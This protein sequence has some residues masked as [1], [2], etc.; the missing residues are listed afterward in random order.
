MKRTILI[1]VEPSST[2]V[3]LFEDGRLN[4]FHIEYKEN[5]RITGN[6]YKGK[7]ENVLTGLE[8]A[9]VNIGRGRN[10]FLNVGEVLDDRTGIN[11][12]VPRSLDVTAGD[13]VMVQVTKEETGQ[14]GARLSDNVS[15]PGRYV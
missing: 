3:S 7:V 4:E 9:F 14:K 11:R 8:S 12:L 10:G 6:I 13:Y 1:D 15:L 2:S 5:N